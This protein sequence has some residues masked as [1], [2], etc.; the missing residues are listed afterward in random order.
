MAPANFVN[1]GRMPFAMPSI[2]QRRISS[3]FC[4][5][6]FHRYGSSSPTLKIP[7]TG[8]RPIVERNSFA[9]RPL[10]HGGSTPCR[11]CRSAI[12]VGASSPMRFMSSG[13]V[14]PPAVLGI[15]HE[16]GL[17]ARTAASHVCHS[18]NSR[19]CRQRM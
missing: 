6:S 7:T 14:A 12:S 10:P 4:T 9:L 18:A 15:T 16:S 19:S 17:I 3:A 11:A 2:A 8:L 1:H 13:P 5:E